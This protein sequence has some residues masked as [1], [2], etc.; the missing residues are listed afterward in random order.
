M[1]EEAIPHMDEEV[2]LPKVF[3]LREVFGGV[4]GNC[5]AEKSIDLGSNCFPLPEWCMN[6]EKKGL[7]GGFVS[8]RKL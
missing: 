7:D 4:L 5:N 6:G 1:V 2:G 8:F 3:L